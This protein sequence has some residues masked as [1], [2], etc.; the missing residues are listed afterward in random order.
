MS[1]RS[2]RAAS[3]VLPAVVFMVLVY[4][5]PLAGVLGQSVME[6]DS[7]R[8]SLAGYREIFGST[9]FYRV[10]WSTLLIRL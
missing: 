9:L 6:A 10:A 7:G 8:W 4:A 2:V 3:F 5:L 1:R